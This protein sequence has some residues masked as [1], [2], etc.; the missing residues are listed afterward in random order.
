MCLIKHCLLQASCLEYQFFP[1]IRTQISSTCIELIYVV[2][3]HDD[4]VWLKVFFLKT[5]HQ[6]HLFQTVGLVADQKR[7]I[8]D[9]AYGNSEPTAVL[10]TKR[11][12]WLTKSR[13]SLDHSNPRGSGERESEPLNGVA[14]YNNHADLPTSR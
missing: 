7:E 12:H 3:D 14:K 8:K 1:F 10:F 11:I 6:A 2:S 13:G 4:G 5:L 9:H